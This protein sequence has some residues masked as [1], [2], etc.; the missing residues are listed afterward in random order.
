MA[1]NQKTS[2][3]VEFPSWVAG[4]GVLK[5]DGATGWHDL[6]PGDKVVLN[7]GD[8]MRV[9]DARINVQRDGTLSIYPD[10]QAR[11]SMRPA[12]RHVPSGVTESANAEFDGEP[13][14]EDGRDSRDADGG[15]DAEA[16]ASF[17]SG[18]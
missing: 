8:Y 13:V 5:R 9:G 11:A 3:V 12:D 16:H 17:Y 15:Y 14:N 18:A 7:P 6:Y 4:E 2:V 10:S 1:K